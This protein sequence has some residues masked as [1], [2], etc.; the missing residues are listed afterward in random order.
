MAGP[1]RKTDMLDDEQSA[2]DIDEDLTDAKEYHTDWRGGCSA[3][4]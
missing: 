4:F 2:S 1:S 3:S